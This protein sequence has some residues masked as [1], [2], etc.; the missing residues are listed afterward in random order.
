MAEY[1]PNLNLFKKDPV[2]D[3]DTTFNIQTMLNDNWDKLDSA[4]KAALDD[5]G[6]LQDGQVRIATGSYVGTG[7]YG[8]SNPC[9]LTSLFHPSLSASQAALQ[10]LPECQIPGHR[11][12]TKCFLNMPTDFQQH[13]KS[14]V[15]W[16]KTVTETTPMV[17]AVRMGKRGI[18]IM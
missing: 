4:V 6:D 15:V 17:C 1:T 3:K 12:T 7:T 11:S 13:S 16:G 14:G 9:S 5:I 18:G 2:A 10:M 8:S